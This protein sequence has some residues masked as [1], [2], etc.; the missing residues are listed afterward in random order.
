MA[1][2]PLEDR[3]R[4]TNER[5]R[6]CGIIGGDLDIASIGY[7]PRPGATGGATFS[8]WSPDGLEYEV[9]VRDVG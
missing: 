1:D 5:D 9:M 4:F 6:L 7:T 8:Y 2:L 3:I